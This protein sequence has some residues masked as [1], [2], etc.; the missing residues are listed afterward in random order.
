[1]SSY[2]LLKKSIEEKALSVGRDP[3]LISLVVVSKF[4]DLN[5][6]MEVYQEGGRLFGESRV[7][8]ALLKLDEAPKDISWHFI[9]N[10]QK[11]KVAK[12][13]GKFALIHSVDS[14]DLAKKISEESLKLNLKSSILLEV[15]TSG[16]LSKHGL[17]V[18]EVRACFKSF[19][20]LKGVE[21]KGFMTMAP[22]TEDKEVIRNTFRT[23]KEV[24]NEIEHQNNMILPHLSM[25]MSND[26]L[27]AIEEGATLLRVGSLIF[28]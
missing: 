15:N 20:N 7:Q 5:R 24:K 22:M 6:I 21:I 1:M 23:L 26:Y 16:E 27:I 25:G 4:Q 12:I 10:L 17:T 2:K 8:E 19:L 3:S 14:F 11:N 13:I 28:K 18:D 9:G